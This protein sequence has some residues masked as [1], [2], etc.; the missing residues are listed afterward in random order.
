MK[1]DD[2]LPSLVGDHTMLSDL[3]GQ[4]A[5]GRV[6][7][8]VHP[9]HVPLVQVGQEHMIT[10]K[11]SVEVD[12]DDGPCVQGPERGEVVGHVQQRLFAPS[13]AVIP[14]TLGTGR[15]LGVEVGSLRL[16]Q[17]SSAKDRVV[18]LEVT[19]GSGRGVD[20]DVVVGDGMVLPAV[21]GRDR[22]GSIVPPPFEFG[23][24][25]AGSAIKS[26]RCDRS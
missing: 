21:R 6:I 24:A 22:D 26:T 4:V 13:T 25:Y 5:H 14:S 1:I 19:F 16:G 7:G 12:G 15:E 18:I 20:R 11:Q 8:P 2:G 9:G 23:L 10:V 3:A 17:V